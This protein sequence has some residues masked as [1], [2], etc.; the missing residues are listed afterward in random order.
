MGERAAA[1]EIQAV[2]GPVK[3]AQVWIEAVQLGR[4]DVAWTMTDPR[5]RLVRAQAWIWNNRKDAD[6]KAD[7]RDELAAALAQD[8][9]DHPLWGDFAATEVHQM[10]EVYGGFQPDAWGASR[11]ASTVGPDYALVL[12]AHLSNEPLI[13]TDQPHVFSLAFLMHAAERGWSL[14]GFADV[15][16]EPGWPPKL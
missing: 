4:Y 15:L 5:L 11:G 3:A 9:P 7:D 1:S 12:F 13:L 6:I 8:R 2:G 16:P 14:A 10:G